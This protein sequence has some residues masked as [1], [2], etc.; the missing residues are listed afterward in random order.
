MHVK[1]RNVE[2]DTYL[3]EKIKHFISPLGQDQEYSTPVHNLLNE[4][5]VELNKNKS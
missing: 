2:W 5:M 3:E 4:G 1:L